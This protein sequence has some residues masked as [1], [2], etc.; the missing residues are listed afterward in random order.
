MLVT[1][2]GKFGKVWYSCNKPHSFAHF[3]FFSF[4]SSTP[5]RRAQSKKI[6]QSL[7]NE[8]ETRCVHT[9][10]HT[11][12]F[13]KY[14]WDV[15]FITRLRQGKGFV[16]CVSLRGPV[17]NHWELLLM[18]CY[19][20]NHM[21]ICFWLVFTVFSLTRDCKGLEDSASKSSETD[22]VAHFVN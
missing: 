9:H 20:L 6:P 17:Y 2:C 12:A 13:V 14:P 7:L 16:H 15:R 4:F 1:N 19:C 10:K 18:I 3:A 5:T 11:K 8:F 21:L 22:Y